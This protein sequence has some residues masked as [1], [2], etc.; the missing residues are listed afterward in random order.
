MRAFARDVPAAACLRYAPRRR[1][2]A[3]RSPAQPWVAAFAFATAL[4]FALGD[5][6]FA[7]ARLATI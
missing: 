6:A 4:D 1:R 7:M 3:A 2:A 5:A